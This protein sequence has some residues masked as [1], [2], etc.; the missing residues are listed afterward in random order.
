MNNLI[1]NADGSLTD[2]ANN[3]CVVL[4]IDPATLVVRYIIFFL[5]P[6]YRGL[7]FFKDA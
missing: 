5:T 3:S 7:E 2:E 6:I 4:Q 1:F